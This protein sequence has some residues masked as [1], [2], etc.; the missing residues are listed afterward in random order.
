M[1]KKKERI[2]RLIKVHTRLNTP[3]S[4]AS[5]NAQVSTYNKDLM[6]DT[7][8]IITELLAEDGI[9]AANGDSK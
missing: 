1:N 5:K 8:N 2:A 3:L 6:I 4:G 7:M 9:F